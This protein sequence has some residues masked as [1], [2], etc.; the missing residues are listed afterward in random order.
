MPLSKDNK[1]GGL[2]NEEDFKFDHL[3]K[4]DFD[5]VLDLL[6]KYFVPYEPINL[7][8]GSTF[9]DK[10]EFIENYVTQSINCGLSM[11]TRTKEGKLIGVSLPDIER[12][13]KVVEGTIP[14][15]KNNVVRHTVEI[16]EHMTNNYDVFQKQG[17]NEILYYAV[18]CVN[19]EY[20]GNNIN[21]KMTKIV[22]QKAIE[23]GINVAY[24]ICTGIKSQASF[25]RN[26]YVTVYETPYK[27]FDFLNLTSMGDNTSIKLMVKKLK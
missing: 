9:P 8:L 23:K 13:G 7:G 15:P 3:R 17:I 24:S 1:N 21:G 22:E 5:E 12:K 4:D 14:A 10:K 27:I 11:G 25:K 16:L 18:V 2:G 26:G 19:P 20:R 6:R